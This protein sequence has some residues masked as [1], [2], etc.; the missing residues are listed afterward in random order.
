MSREALAMLPVYGVLTRR[1]LLH[2]SNG[3]SRRNLATLVTHG[4]VKISGQ[5]RTCSGIPIIKS[6]V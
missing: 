3:Y 6:K 2:L 4:P 1:A 5:N